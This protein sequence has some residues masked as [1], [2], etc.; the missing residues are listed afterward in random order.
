MKVILV[1]FGKSMVK[2]GLD[3][4][5]NTLAIPICTGTKK[6]RLYDQMVQ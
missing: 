2:H 3:L 6:I 5:E 1:A 4:Q